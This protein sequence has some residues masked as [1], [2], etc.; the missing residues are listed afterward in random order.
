[1][2]TSTNAVFTFR[3]LGYW[4]V[5]EWINIHGGLKIEIPNREYYLAEYQTEE[6]K[7]YL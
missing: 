6:T 5:I 4:F 7:K 3:G 1:M 2:G